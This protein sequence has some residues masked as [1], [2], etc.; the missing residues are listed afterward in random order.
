[1]I[2]GTVLQHGGV[3]SE[4]TFCAFSSELALRWGPWC[5]Q[6]VYFWS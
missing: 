3:S 2:T 6:V 1:M 4:E 5:S